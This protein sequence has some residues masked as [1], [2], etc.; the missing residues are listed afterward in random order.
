MSFHLH[1]ISP[2]NSTRSHV[3]LVLLIVVVCVVMFGSV[4]FAEE[5]T[6]RSNS[7]ESTPGMRLPPR[8]NAHE[9]TTTPTAKRAS[10]GGGLWTTV[11]SLAAII[12]C[13]GLV[14]YWL[15]P[16]L[17][18]PRGLPIEALELLGRRT[19]EQ[20]IAI[21]LVRCGNKVLVLGV[22]PE[23][24]R[25]LSEITDPA[26]VQRLIKACHA[27]RDARTFISPESVA[28]GLGGTQLA[29]S[30]DQTAV[31]HPGLRSAAQRVSSFKTEEPRR[32]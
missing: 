23:G 24:A 8:T 30:A 25:T 9:S 12:G 32:G 17:G 4:S 13:L 18:V 15:R 2:R 20:K 26:E 29:H 31:P 7:R 1:R 3:G 22:S 16:Y 27:P 14:G 21:H 28:G 6:A 10:T 11:I 19:I 5:D